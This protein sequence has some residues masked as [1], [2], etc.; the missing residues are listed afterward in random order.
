MFIS[1]PQT[2]QIT[3]T[4][5]P[6][7]DNLLI[8]SMS[9]GLFVYDLICGQLINVSCPNRIELIGSDLELV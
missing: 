3:L 9:H 1:W 5:S 8:I 2:E 6:F 4:D 7:I